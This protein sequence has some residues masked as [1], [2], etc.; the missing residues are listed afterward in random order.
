M[1]FAHL[2]LTGGKR[3]VLWRVNTASNEWYITHLLSYQMYPSS[4]SSFSFPYCSSQFPVDFNG[5]NH[6]EV[7]SCKRRDD[8]GSTISR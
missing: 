4:V 6:C 3:L 7:H 2:I 8:K 5:A 1:A